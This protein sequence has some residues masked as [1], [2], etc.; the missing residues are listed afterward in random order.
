MFSPTPVG[1]SACST[2]FSG[3]SRFR[4]SRS[5][6]EWA[7]QFCLGMEH[8]NARGVNCHRDIKPANIL[9]SEQ[10]LKISDFGLS[11]AA[12]KGAA[13]LNASLV[14]GSQSG[15]FGFSVLRSDGNVRCGTPGY[16]PPEVYRGEPADVRS[17]IYSF[18]LVLWQ[19]ATHSPSP[20]FVGSFRGDI[21]AYMRE[22]YDRQMSGRIPPVA[23]PFRD[24]V[25][26]CLNPKPSKRYSDFG[27]LRRALEPIFQNLT[28]KDFVVPSADEQ[29]AR[30]WNNKGMSLSALGRREEAIICYDKA[31]AIDAGEAKIWSNKGFDLQELGRHGEAL[32]C[33]DKALT[34]APQLDG[35]WSNKGSC[36][37]AMGRFEEALVCYD[38][39][40]VTDFR[41]GKTWNNKGRVLG[42]LG[43]S[44]EAIGCYQEALAVDPRYAEAWNNL[45]ACLNTLGKHKEAL[46]C[47]EKAL[48][49]DPQYSHAWFNNGIALAALGQRK[50]ALAS[51][52][53]ALAIDPRDAVTWFNKGNSFDAL[54]RNDEAIAC[55]EKALSINRRYHEAWNNKG[56]TLLALGQLEAAVVCFD[57]ALAIDP[58]DATRW[59]NKAYAEDE[60]G[61]SAAAVKSYRRFLDLASP[62]HTAQIAH[63]R[64][65]I[66]RLEGST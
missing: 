4:R 43:R 49:I 20:P 58:H 28:G 39:A 34:I 9:I 16:M 37:D 13:A 60:L 65:R 51:Y 22:A 12:A 55:Y 62:Q 26:R 23:R 47:Y 41:N 3:A 35:V 56:G 19:M 54:G 29:T 1:A 36:L 46:A 31:L 53:K 21:E 45:G 42:S 27:E 52:D 61:R 15:C 57:N 40:L 30:F 10:V 50:D 7:I 8:A 2:I 59:F 14:A 64:E 33:Y 17:D 6:A 11:A 48:A 25:E 5:R 32:E 63:A 66:V 38:N 44:R 18:G 24:V